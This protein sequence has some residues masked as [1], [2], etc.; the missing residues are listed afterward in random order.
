MPSRE[1]PSLTEAVHDAAQP[2][3]RGPRPWTPKGETK[4]LIL[5]LPVELHRQLRQHALD[6][7]TTLQALGVKAL[8]DLLGERGE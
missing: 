8:Q 6:H 4:S 5:R 1:K 3:A 7:D 2:D